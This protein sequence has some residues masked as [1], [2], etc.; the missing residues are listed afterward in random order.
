MD[1]SSLGHLKEERARKPVPGRPIE[2]EYR[3]GHCARLG[4]QCNMCALFSFPIGRMLPTP[5]GLRQV[6]GEA[7]QASCRD[8]LIM[9]KAVGC[10]PYA[11]DH[12]SAP[13][14]ICQSVLATN[15]RS[16]GAIAIA[17]H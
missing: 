15:G 13:L 17:V 16:R 3:Y 6:L 11:A 14:R 10:I 4:A 12:L 7:Y 2:L 5:L 9:D 1:F 8:F